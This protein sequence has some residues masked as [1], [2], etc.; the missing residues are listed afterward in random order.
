MGTIIKAWTNVYGIKASC[1]ILNHP[2]I[3]WRKVLWALNGKWPPFTQDSR[4]GKWKLDLAKVLIY[5]VANGQSDVFNTRVSA[6]PTG[7]CSRIPQG[8]LHAQ[9]KWT[10]A[11]LQDWTACFHRTGTADQNCSR[12]LFSAG[13]WAGL[14]GSSETLGGAS[15]RV[16]CL[17]V[18][19]SQSRWGAN[20]MGAVPSFQALTVPVGRI[21]RLN[22]RECGERKL[23]M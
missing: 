15:Q 22:I 18:S 23:G 19:F 4:S 7:Y 17:S 8:Q 6:F 9:S 14:S 16:L 21:L 13:P 20:M 10:G 3:K 12:P 11:L 2:K 5:R 1:D